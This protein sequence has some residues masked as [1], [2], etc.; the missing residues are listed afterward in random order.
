MGI[1]STFLD[2]FGKKKTV[3]VFEILEKKTKVFGGDFFF[4]VWEGEKRKTKER[5]REK[6]KERI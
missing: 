4:L 3:F 5:K 6:E 2:L 1:S